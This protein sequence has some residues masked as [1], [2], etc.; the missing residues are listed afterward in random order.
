MLTN[1]ITELVPPYS[2]K[3]HELYK[4][5]FL[6]VNLH[7]QFITFVIYVTNLIFFLDSTIALHCLLLSYII[8][9]YLFIWNICM[10]FNIYVI[11][12]DKAMVQNMQAFNK[13]VPHDKRTSF[14]HKLPKSSEFCEGNKRLT[15]T[16]FFSTVK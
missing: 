1:R 12:K 3:T 14:F 9:V 2:T 8:I 7:V 10:H 15:E 5:K 11:I 6:G 16:N 13:N 4:T